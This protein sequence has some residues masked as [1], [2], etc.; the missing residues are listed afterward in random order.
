VVETIEEIVGWRIEI[1]NNNIP[2][3]FHGKKLFF[4]LPTTL[5]RTFDDGTRSEWQKQTKKSQKVFL[6]IISIF[7][8]DVG[9]CGEGC[10]V[11]VFRVRVHVQYPEK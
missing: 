8:G 11:Q 10:F 6:A 4:C 3:F 1:A 2:F 7:V 5:Q 9:G